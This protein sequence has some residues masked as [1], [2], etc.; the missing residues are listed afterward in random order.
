MMR[1]MLGAVALVLLVACA[2]VAGLLLARATAR[3]REIAVRRA[4]GASR[5]R[6]V[7]QLLTESVILALLGGTLGTLIGVWGLAGVRAMLPLDD[8]PFWMK[9]EVDRTVL[10]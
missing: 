7:R 1:I 5:G 4:L 2:N 6:I 8:L 9:F 3:S 10:L